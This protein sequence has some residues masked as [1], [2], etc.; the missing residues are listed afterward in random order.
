M[1]PWS[2]LAGILFAMASGSGLAQNVPRAATSNWMVSETTSP[3]DYKPLVVAM[4][5]SRDSPEKS[6]MELSIH[7]RNGQ[8]NLVVTGSAISGSEDGYAISYRIN[9]D[10][11]V[12]AGAGSPS[13]APGVAFR[14][15]VIRLLQ[16]FPDEGEIVIRLTARTGVVREGSFVLDGLGRVRTKIASACK[17][18]KPEN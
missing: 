1:R 17:W 15:D 18:P 3:V 7:C 11:P 8:T 16:S 6:A 2:F 9:G 14:G 10:K 12:E 4:T 5:R 13:F